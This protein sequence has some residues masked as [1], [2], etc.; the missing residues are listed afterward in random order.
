MALGPN[1]AQ[2][3]QLPARRF[4]G[5]TFPPCGSVW[6]KS[7]SLASKAPTE[8]PLVAQSIGGASDC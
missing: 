4:W 8:G 5:G 2:V 7:V 6:L 1:V 3:R